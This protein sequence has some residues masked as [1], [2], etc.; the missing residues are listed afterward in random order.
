MK[1]TTYKNYNLLLD[2]RNKKYIA[3]SK[4]L[5]ITRYETNNIIKLYLMI[6]GFCK[7]VLCSLK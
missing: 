6:N 1:I 5:T 2:P 3:I 4:D 7:D